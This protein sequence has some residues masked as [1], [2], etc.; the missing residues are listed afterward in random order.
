MIKY[1]YTTIALVCMAVFGQLHAQTANLNSGCIPLDVQFDA[2]DQTSYYWDFKDGAVSNLQNPQHIFTAAGDYNVDLYTSQGGTLVG[3]LLIKVYP[4]LIVE[5]TTDDLSGCIPLDVQFRPEI[6]KHPDIII[7]DVIWT[8]GDGGSSNDLEALYTYNQSGTYDVS[9]KVITSVGECDKTVQFDD[10]ITVSGVEAKFNANKYSSC[11]APDVFTFTNITTAEPGHTYEWDFGNGETSSDYQAGSI[12]Y[13]ENGLYEIALSVTN[14]TGCVSTAKRFIN[15]GP[16]VFNLDFDNVICFNKIETLQNNTVADEFIW[17]FEDSPHLEVIDQDMPSPSLIANKTGTYEVKLTAISFL[18]CTSDTTFTLT[19]DVVNTNFNLGPDVTCADQFTVILEAED[20][21]HQ[22]Y[23][24]LDFNPDGTNFTTNLPTATQEYIAPDRDSFFVNYPDTLFYTLAVVSQYGCVDSMQNGLVIRKP[25]AFFVPD[26]VLGIGSLTV[27]F[28]DQSYSE[29]PI[30][31]RVW[32]WGDGGTDTFTNN[33]LNHTRTYG[34]GVYWVRLTITN[35]EGCI[36]E[37]ELIKITV[38]DPDD[39]T[40]LI[41]TA[42]ANGNAGDFQICVGDSVTVIYLNP[43]PDLIDFHFNTDIGRFNQCWKSDI[44]THAFLYPGDFSMGWTLEVE[45]V[46]FHEDRIGEL[47]V[48]GAHSKIGY[49]TDCDDIYN[50]DFES[51]SINANKLEWFI[52]GQMVST[53]E[54]FSHNFTNLGRHLIELHATDT[55]SPCAAHVDT[56]SVWITDIKADFE[57]PKN[58][59]D[60]TLYLLDASSSLD[61]HDDCH[62]GYL[63]N[64]DFHRPREVGEDSLYHQFPRGR[65]AIT[66]TTEDINGC[67]DSKT[68]WVN[69]YGMDPLFPLDSTFCLPNT[70]QLTD[71]TVADTT[72]VGWEWSFGDTNQNPTYTFTED[73]LDSLGNLI[74]TLTVEDAIGCMDEYVQLVDLY[75]PISTIKVNKGPNV[76]TGETI[77]FSADDFEAQGSF[78]TYEWDFG[79][80]GTSNE[81][82]PQI[83]FTEP[84]VTDVMLTFTED[85]SGCMG[86]TT[87]QITA[88]SAPVADFMT[89]VDTLETLCHPETIEFTNL[90]QT[91]GPVFY[92]WDFG[93]GI[94]SG[95]EDPAISY[96]KGIY[97]A[98]MIIRSVYGCSDTLTQMFELIGPEGLAEIDKSEICIGDE[99]TLSV[100]DLV[101]VNSYTWDFGDGT[102]ADDISPVTHIYDLPSDETNISLIL[103]STDTGCELIQTIPVTLHSVFADFELANQEGFCDGIFSLTDLSLGADTYEWIFGN[104]SSSGTNPE[105]EYESAGEVEVQLTVTDAATGCEHTNL[106]TILLDG[107]DETGE[108]PNV[109]SPNGDDRNDFF[110]VTTAPGNEESIEVIEFKVYNRWGELIYDNDTPATG[111]NGFHESEI[112]PAEVYSYYIEYSVDGCNNRSAKGNITLVR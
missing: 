36:D 105:F 65:Q 97:T 13:T 102:T 41:G 46:F 106:Q 40:G 100:T 75:E 77:T 27:N 73:D 44:G 48:D 67:M 53:Q 26:E 71:Q 4:D 49:E 2:P 14:T 10:Y 72:A 74:V 19:I 82:I 8:F 91:E 108:L 89:S 70:V 95:L 30:V 12:T 88:I 92:N 39:L 3:S 35:E 93:N 109:F 43:A 61:V 28:Q 81:D 6:T 34:I 76:C 18:G 62:E 98:T 51:K 86:D 37:S 59:C 80:Y 55:N 54:Q 111:W 60:S 33:E 21:N 38:I 11:D 17:E 68:K 45:G 101:D 87:I 50:V 22:S 110:N 96:D 31:S 47:T 84:G 104:Q 83:T 15:I 94:T 24:W 23:T 79:Q 107:I 63:W 25:E 85:S 29:Q 16:P 7:Q 112:A 58:M 5:I 99:I 90:S 103:R 42:T 66:L 32:D 78:L 52:D 20:L 56:T 9:I 1:I 64:F 57:V 69:V